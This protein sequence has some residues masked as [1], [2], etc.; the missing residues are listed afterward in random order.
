MAG[1]IAARLKELGIDLPNLPAPAGAYVPYT[2]SGNILFVSG[3]IPMRDGAL[4]H[5]GKVGADLSIEDGH[6]CARVCALNI[7]AQVAAACGGD[8]DRVSRCLKLGGFVN[9]GPDFNDHPKVINGASELMI[10]VFG[11]AGKHARFA[12]GAPSLP[13]GSAVEVEAVFELK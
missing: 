4:S 7:L 10:E 2:L 8:L 13:L 12:V 6:A 9:C 3:Q 5:K 11:D 1:T